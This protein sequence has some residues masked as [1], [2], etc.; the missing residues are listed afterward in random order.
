MHFDSANAAGVPNH[1]TELLRGHDSCS[2]QGLPA[3]FLGQPAAILPPMHPF[4]RQDINE[5]LVILVDSSE[6][7]ARMA[8]VCPAWW[9]AARRAAGYRLRALAGHTDCVWASVS[10]P[11]GLVASGSLDQTVRVWKVGSGRLVRTLVGHTSF[12]FALAVLPGGLLASGSYDK[13]VRVWEVESGRLV[14]TLAGHTSYVY[15]LVGLP[16]GLLASGSG[17]ETVFVWRI[18]NDVGQ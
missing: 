16:G 3:C 10:L 11:G 6:M 7:L 5:H 12:V 13:T 8:L 15:A 18:A 14:R 1:A 4:D 9:R 2:Q 17:D